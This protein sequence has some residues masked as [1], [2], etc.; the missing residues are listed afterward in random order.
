MEGLGLSS[1]WIAGVVAALVIGVVLWKAVKLALK[2]VVF[3]VGAA[4]IAV[5]VLLAA[6]HGGAALPLPAPPGQVSTP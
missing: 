1:S 5:I 4:V 2:V 6:Q 3:V